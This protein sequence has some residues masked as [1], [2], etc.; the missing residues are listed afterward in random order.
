M[1]RYRVPVPVP[2]KTTVTGAVESARRSACDR[3]RTVTTEG[4]KRAA[5][6]DGVV[7]DINFSKLP[8]TGRSVTL[9]RHV[10]PVWPGEFNERARRALLQDDPFVRFRRQSV[11]PSA[12]A[13]AAR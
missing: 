3:K 11:R 7:L 1:S 10:S 2:D 8:R 5:E 9:Y 4:E 13:A 12:A 6:I